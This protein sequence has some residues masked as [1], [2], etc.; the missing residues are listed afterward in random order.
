MRGNMS[1]EDK[2][3]L[4]TGASS[5]IGAACAEYFA[6]EGAR[7]ALVGRNADKF[8][9][10]LD[11]IQ[12]NGTKH[13]PLVILSDLTTEAENIIT[14][15]I[16]K[17]Q[18]LGILINCAGIAK[19]GN[20]D[21]TQLEDFDQIFATNVRGPF[22]LTQ[23]AVPHLITSK[24]NIVNIS[25]VLA[26]R[27]TTELLSYAM[28]KAAV[29]HFTRCVA[30]ELASKGVRVNTVNPGVVNTDFHQHAGVPPENVSA[31]L[32]EMAKRHPLGRVAE[33]QDVV[34]AVAFVCGDNAN[35]ITG[36]NLPVD[37]GLNINIPH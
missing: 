34:Q 35:F 1:F 26:M 24:G 25:S 15:T 8:A 13:E 33:T 32:Q 19:I 21:N 28:S 3:I 6:K 4:I 18:Q 2:V 16:E 20:L 10:L 30:L 7:L 37:G 29:D 27:A 31:A 36:I 9:N 22:E 23:R 11:H 17:Y 5:G 12:E 14:E